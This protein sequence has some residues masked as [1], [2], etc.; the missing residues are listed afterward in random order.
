MATAKKSAP[1]GAP[2]LVKAAPAK[3]VKAAAKPAAK[4]V[5]A[6]PAKAPV[7]S[8]T[9]KAIAKI[10][11]SLVKLNERKA[12]ITADIN[13]LKDQRAALKAPPAV[14]AAAPAAPAKPAKAAK[15]AKAK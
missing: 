15:A 8:K 1:K 4:K 13:A 12:K 6:K 9:A 2:T 11:A 5:A 14:V 10:N 7:V 3:A